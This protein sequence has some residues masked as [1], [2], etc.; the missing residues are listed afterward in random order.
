[1]ASALRNDFD[2]GKS[3]TVFT[4]HR[5][6]F[7]RLQVSASCTLQLNE[8]KPVLTDWNEKHRNFAR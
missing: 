1:M 7:R 2:D 6:C 4:V 5:A 8:M 3:C